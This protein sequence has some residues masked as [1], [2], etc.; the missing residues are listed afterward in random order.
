VAVR[1]YDAKPH[2][3][4]AIIGHDTDGIAIYCGETVTLKSDGTGSSTT[5]ADL[6]TLL[7]RTDPDLA[8]GTPS[9]V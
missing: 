2:H 1:L 4:R 7:L 3:C 8:V 5:L 6:L 9:R